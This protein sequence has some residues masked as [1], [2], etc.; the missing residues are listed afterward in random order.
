MS[1]FALWRRLVVP[2]SYSSLC[3]LFSLVMCSK[4]TP[5]PSNPPVVPLPSRVLSYLVQMTQRINY[6]QHARSY[7]TIRN[8]ISFENAGVA[9]NDCLRYLVRSLQDALN[10]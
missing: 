4:I 3:K 6:I 2:V 1:F 7:Y 5:R 10:P 8:C 9:L